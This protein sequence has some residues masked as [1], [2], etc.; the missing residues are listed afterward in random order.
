MRLYPSS[1]DCVSLP[2]VSLLPS[3][4]RARI[5]CVPPLAL[6]SPREYVC[7]AFSVESLSVS[8]VPPNG[9][10]DLWLRL[11]STE[12]VS[13]PLD[14]RFFRLPSTPVRVPFLAPR[15]PCLSS[16]IAPIYLLCVYLSFFSSLAPSPF[17]TTSVS[18]VHTDR[19]IR[20]NTRGDVPSTPCA[21]CRR[22]A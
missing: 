11:A 14:R 4:S 15:C 17:L 7:H 18:L 1:P 20:S 10:V 22:G 16:L 5:L 3:L 21:V 9:P 6:H 8:F 12:S 13:L 19:E 2:P